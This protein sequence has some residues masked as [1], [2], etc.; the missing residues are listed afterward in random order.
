MNHTV[1]K[2]L[3]GLIIPDLAKIVGKFVDDPMAL[4]V[5][6]GPRTADKF[7]KSSIEIS[8]IY[9]NQLVVWQN[10]KRVRRQSWTDHKKVFY[11]VNSRLLPR[12]NIGQGGSSLEFQRVP[13][14]VFECDFISSSALTK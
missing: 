3:D 13:N 11:V 1:L 2:S 6:I 9:T 14:K 4:F 12:L 7:N 5:F 10:T 8:S